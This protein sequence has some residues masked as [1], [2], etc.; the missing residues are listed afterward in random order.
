MHEIELVKLLI[1][2]LEDRKAENISDRNF[3]LSMVDIF[4][5]SIK[6]WE[7]KND[8][9]TT[10]LKSVI[11]LLQVIIGIIIMRHQHTIDY[12]IR[13]VGKNT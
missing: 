11:G 12:L 9:D 4:K 13:F 6:Y 8:I 7:D 10:N 5:K 3:G 1:T 2:D